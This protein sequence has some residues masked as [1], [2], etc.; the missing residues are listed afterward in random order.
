MAGKGRS[1]ILLGLN[2][3]K[4][5]KFDVKILFNAEEIFLK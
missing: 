2:I 3:A 4:T 5:W 1:P